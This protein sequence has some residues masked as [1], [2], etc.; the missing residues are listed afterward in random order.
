VSGLTLD[1]GAL[2]AI[3]KGDRRVLAAI[4]FELEQE[5]RIAIPAGA[6]AQAWRDGRRQVR[7]V[8][9]LAGKGVVREPLDADR[10]RGAGRLCGVTGTSD[11]VDASV[12]LCARARGHAVLTSD[13]GD[14]R[15]LD[16]VLRLVAV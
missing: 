3:E 7:L 2:N 9:F 16:G 13:V 8:R 1:T 15:R 14:L 5:H 12:V 6:L 10:A 4:E 11:I